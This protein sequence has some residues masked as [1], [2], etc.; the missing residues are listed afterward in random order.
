MLVT[1]QVVMVRDGE[2]STSRSSTAPGLATNDLLLCS[3]TLRHCIRTTGTP[4]E[5]RSETMAGG[6]SMLW[7]RSRRSKPSRVAPSASSL[8]ASTG[9]PASSRTPSETTGPNSREMPSASIRGDTSPPDLSAA[10]TKLTSSLVSIGGWNARSSTS[11]LLRKSSVNASVASS[12]WPSNVRSSGSPT[13]NRLSVG[14]NPTPAMA[15]SMVRPR[16][17]W[18]SPGRG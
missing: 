2:L 3:G 5:A 18:T 8:R 12:S 13:W 4:P 6:L 9:P 10:L 7:T 14:R 11:P 17:S 16:T 15:P 1:V